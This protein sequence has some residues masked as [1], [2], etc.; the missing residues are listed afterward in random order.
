MLTT[1]Q[2]SG[3]NASLIGTVF[4]VIASPGANTTNYKGL[5]DSK[6][7]TY[8]YRVAARNNAG[9]SSYSNV[10]TATP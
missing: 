7:Q 1:K 6:E 3:L 8:Y 2:A 10:V 9:L 5:D 4:S